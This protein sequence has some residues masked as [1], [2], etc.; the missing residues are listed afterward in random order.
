MGGHIGGEIASASTIDRLG[1]VVEAG[2]VTPKTIEKALVTR[3]QG[4]RV[5]PRDDRRRH[6]HDADRRVSSTSATDAPQW[7]TLNIGDSRVYLMRDGVIEQ[8]TTDH[9]VVQELDRRGPAQPR[10]G[11]EPPVRQRHHARRRARARASRPTTCGSTSSTATASSSARTGSRRSSPTT[12]SSTSSTRTAD[13]GRR[14]R[15]DAG[16]RARERRAR[17]HHDH[18]ARRR[19]A[20]GS[21]RAARAVA[22]GD[23]S[24]A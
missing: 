8:I 2:T 16:C 10:R 18:R 7:V 12:A 6:G 4:H 19:G 21:R 23:S 13:P 24:P 14:G 22:V 20:L 1:S 9:S 3:G 17:Q 5:A 15:R 11:R